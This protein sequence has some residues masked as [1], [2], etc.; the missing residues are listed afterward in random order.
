MRND[1]V[2]R[3]QIDDVC[4]P[5]LNDWHS[6]GNHFAT[7]RRLVGDKAL[8]DHRLIADQS[9][10]GRRNIAKIPALLLVKLIAASSETDLQL[11]KDLFET[12]RSPMKPLSDQI[13]CSQ[14][15]CDLSR[16]GVNLPI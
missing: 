6:L 12:S 4:K 3:R 10:I 14:H 11:T 16:F 13:S 9:Q 5:M 1:T 8:I 7:D 2:M 15:T